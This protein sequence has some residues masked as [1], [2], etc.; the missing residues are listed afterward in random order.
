MTVEKSFFDGRKKTGDAVVVHDPLTGLF[1]RGFWRLVAEREIARARR[2]GG[3]LSVVAVSIDRFMEMSVERGHEAGDAILKAVAEAIESRLRK[4]DLVARVGLEEFLI[5]LPG[6]SVE[7][8]YKCAEDV[9]A[10]VGQVRGGPGHP[11]GR[12]DVSFGI[13]AFPQ[14]G[15]TPEALR[16]AAEGALTCA[17]EEG[18]HRAVVAGG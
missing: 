3:S 13:A 16:E 14:N 18:R 7:E 15:E 1:N 8:A 17:K 6:T 11:I 9:R 10:A 5:L 4:E 12:I 2:H